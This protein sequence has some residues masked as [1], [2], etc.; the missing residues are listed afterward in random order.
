MALPEADGS[1]ASVKENLERNRL[2]FIQIIQE[3]HTLCAGADIV[4]ELL[5]LTQAEK[6]QSFRS[7]LHPYYVFRQ[8]A[9]DAVTIEQILGRLANT[10]QTTLQAAQYIV[11]AIN[12]K[13]EGFSQQLADIDD[14][15]V[16][17]VVKTDKSIHNANSVY[18]YYYCDVVPADNRDNFTS[19]VA[20]LSQTNGCCL[21]LQLLPTSF[22]AQEVSIINELAAE[23]NQ[24]AGGLQVEGQFYRDPAAI[25]PYK[26]MSYYNANARAPL[27]TYNILAIGNRAD[28][29]GMAAKLVSLLKSGEKA[30]ST[31]EF[32][33]HDLS[34]SGLDL[35]G[36]FLI[37]P[38]NLN[39]Q[40]MWLY[41]SREALKAFPFMLALARMPLL[42]T[43]DECSAF[44]RLP[45]H[46]KNMPALQGRQT[47][48][49]SEQFS[50]A[51]IDEDNIWV[52]QVN[53]EARGSTAVQIGCP[54]K[55][56]ARHAL[57]VGAPGTGK[58]TFSINL[59]LQ[60]TS[61]QVPFLAIEP[62]KSEYRA[63]VD[64]VSGLQVF[65]P[66]NNDVCP[67]II[68]PFIPPGGI[69]LEQYIPSLASA[70]QATF[71]M[72]Q[73]LD[74][75]FLK[76][77]RQ[78]YSQ[79]G[80]RGYSTRD[81]KEAQPFGLF[82][83][84]RVFKRLVD[85]SEY[86]Q[87]I[88]GNLQ[89]AGVLRL[90][91]LIE[92]NSNIYDTVKTIP[93]EDLLSAPTV[94]ELNSIE[95]AEQKSLLMALLLINICTYTRHNHVSGSAL[96]NVSLIDEAHVLFGSKKTQEG[97][98]NPV[99]ATTKV[100]QDMVAEIRSYGTGVI[101]ADQEPS[102][103]GREILANTDVKLV[104]RLN[105]GS[106]RSMIA[107]SVFS[108]DDISQQIARLKDGEALFAF[109]QLQEPQVV[110]TPDVRAEGGIRLDLPDAELMGY[111]SYWEGHQDLLKP[112]V[113]CGLSAACVGGCDFRVRADAEHYAELYLQEY[114]A[115]IIDGQSLYNYASLLDKWFARQGIEAG[116][117]GQRLLN[118]A[119]IRLLRDALL[120][121][122]F[123]I[124]DANIR[125]ILE[126]LLVDEGEV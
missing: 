107:D 4:I 122:N 62:T 43:A 85:E 46:E 81:D 88:K 90:M 42:M 126:K 82:E 38:W 60:F 101:I 13:D 28:C 70:F 2:S 76:A 29:T 17:S 64:A 7:S 53:S 67:F 105:E 47:L 54:P 93:I 80:W 32:A 11:R 96:R 68:N 8:I 3:L 99:A 95:N 12:A 121:K 31:P 5:W 103:V 56:F 116:V 125:K 41:Q 74:M 111:Q 9:S 118:C 20:A 78:T 6:N 89:S 92:Q 65:T 25:E 37:Y 75:L 39:S 66:G 51:V 10:L 102:K 77:I 63:L 123:K 59:L 117:D 49:A 113:E 45:L 15:C 94:L 16:L 19:L 34:G 40:M 106:D 98:A 58:T 21:A 120:Q 108:S 55:A 124:S 1:S 27:F 22:N 50:A 61:K 69:K 86:E 23:Y 48:R 87:R 52:G 114:S 57:I 14:S 100:L 83:F 104:F 72:Q 119:R 79:Y 35:D 115:R 73:P 109:S 18:P 71:S 24:I 91:N 26:V 112:F 36:Q 97:E 110:K 84:I 33:C 44:F 30:L